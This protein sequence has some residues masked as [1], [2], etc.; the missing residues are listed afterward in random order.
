MFFENNAGLNFLQPIY[1]YNYKRSLPQAQ[2]LKEIQSVFGLSS[3]NKSIISKWYNRFDETKT[4]W[5]WNESLSRF[6][7]EVWAKE[8]RA[9]DANQP[10]SEVAP[11]NREHASEVRRIGPKIREGE[12]EI[13]EVAITISDSEDEVR[14]Q[15][16]QVVHADHKVRKRRDGQ[17]RET[18]KENQKVGCEV[19]HA[20]SKVRGED[21]VVS[22]SR[23]K[24]CKV[25]EKTESIEFNHDS[26]ERSCGL[27]ELDGRVSTLGAELR[28]YGPSDCILI[29]ISD[30]V[31]SEDKFTKL[32]S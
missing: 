29:S 12:R 6:E 7:K 13:Q 26:R 19:R 28:K 22:Y 23:E 25:K 31:I 17:V 18:G 3:T 24:D 5:R 21:G 20:A 15:E 32:F 1:Y 10:N 9:A 11:E 2:C 30:E 27:D 8:E 16:T 14:S 4:N